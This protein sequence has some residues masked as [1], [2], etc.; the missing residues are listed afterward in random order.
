MP[1]Q[2]RDTDESGRG[3]LQV[4]VVSTVWDWYPE[5]GGKVVRAAGLRPSG[6][7]VGIAGERAKPARLAAQI[8]Q[9]GCLSQGG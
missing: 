5:D 6:V 9:A 3:L 7:A 2:P 4:E 1:G 8:R